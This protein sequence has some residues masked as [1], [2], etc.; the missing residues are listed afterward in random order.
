M[1]NQVLLYELNEVPWEVWDRYIEVRPES[2]AARLLERAMQRTTIDEDPVWLMPWRTWP[3]FHRSLLTEDHGAMDQGQDP[4]TYRGTP[5]WDVVEA[6]GLPVGLFGVLQSW[7]ARDFRHGGFYVPDS[8]A[9]TVET[10]P[11]A[12]ERFQAFN[13]A[14]TKENNFSS[15]EPVKVSS[16]VATAADAARRGLSPWSSAQLA[17][18]MIRERR[19]RRYLASR[20]SVQV[21][22]CFDLFWRLHK[23]ANPALSIF[24]S[25]HVASMMHRFWGDWM[26]GYDSNGYQPDPVYGGFIVTAMDY[27]DHQLG[28]MRAWVD[29]HPG[30]TLVVAGSM[31]MGPI[32]FDPT[33]ASHVVEDAQKLVAALGVPPCELG[34]AMYPVISLLFPTSQ[35]AEAAAPVLESVSTELGPMFVDFRAQGRTL[36]FYVWMNKDH[37]DIPEKLSWTDAAGVQRTGF[38]GDLGIVIRHRAGGGNTAQHLP[39]GIFIAYGEGIEADA[40]RDK[41]DILDAA[42]SILD[43]MGIRPEPDMQGAPSIFSLALTDEHKKS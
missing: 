13:V 43:L 34:P 8:F 32:E 36:S 17:R 27:F 20:P 33:P 31:G 10:F 25:N 29:S 21:L 26:E 30:T 23:S 14:M 2:N 16:L 28:V 6:A 3:T 9:R 19:D 42:P 22:L 40:S 15:E 4:E 5:I 35:E 18:H 1:A 38:I 24:F 12:L 7:P 39:D 11:H 37:E 41:V